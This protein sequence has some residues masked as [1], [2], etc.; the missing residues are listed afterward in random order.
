MS[1]HTE[2][3]QLIADLKS[4]DASVSLQALHAFTKMT[5]A[6]AVPELLRALKSG[7]KQIMDAAGLGLISIGEPAVALLVR[8]LRKEKDW[9]VRCHSAYILGEIGDAYATR[10]LLSAI[11]GKDFLVKTNCL[12]TLGK[13]KDPSASS[14]LVRLLGNKKLREEAA[15]VLEEIGAPASRELAN[16][17]KNKATGSRAAKVLLKIGEPSV[18]ALMKTLHGR[19]GLARR[20][21]ARVLA[22]IGGAS[23][24]TA[25]TDALSAKSKR[26]RVAASRALINLK[27]DGATPHLID[28]LGDSSA[29]VVKN[30]ALAIGKANPTGMDDLH[31]LHRA[32]KSFAQEHGEKSPKWVLESL[33]ATYKKWSSLLGRKCRKVHKKEEILPPPKRFRNPPPLQKHYHSMY[34]IPMIRRMG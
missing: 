30:A 5:D 28:A 6:G 1:T 29:R 11:R 32:I 14:A 18:P 20:R 2:V 13:I 19:D 7:D 26:V 27:D 34:R 4:G 15:R 22:R 16:A 25:L 10:A 24:A 31:N 23:T 3:K 17:L 9:G 12:R 8:A 33:G 21:A